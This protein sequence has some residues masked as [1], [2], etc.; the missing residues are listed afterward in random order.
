MIRMRMADEEQHVFKLHHVFPGDMPL[1]NAARPLLEGL[2][3]VKYEQRAA[4]L[5]GKPAVGKI[6]DPQ[7]LHL[8]SSPFFSS[9]LL[10]AK[11]F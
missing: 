5:R 7:R 2:G 9:C 1:R 8:S 4:H 6:G 11:N 10:H 3:I